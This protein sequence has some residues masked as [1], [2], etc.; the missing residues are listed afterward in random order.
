MPGPRR[1]LI[2]DD[3]PLAR[4]RIRDLLS[5]REDVMVIGE[6]ADGQAA[7][8]DTAQLEPDIL[9]LDVQMPAMDGFEVV[10]AITDIAN[11][12]R[13]PI[14]IF[15]TAY[16]QYAIRAFDAMALDYLRK[17]VSRARLDA[18]LGRA[19]AQLDLLE[20]A[21]RASHS[22]FGGDRDARETTRALRHTAGT[23]AGHA[24][25][26]AVRD[27]DVVRFVQPSEIDWVD[28]A[29]NYV[30]LHAGGK[31]YL[32]RSPIGAFEAR[33]D[34]RHFMRVHRSAIV[35]LDRVH[36]IEPFA[37]GE[38]VLV[39]TDGTRLRSSRAYGARLRQLVRDGVG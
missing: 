8:V 4:G 33:L 11:G 5:E 22:V 3:E 24:S 37:R 21:E 2:V 28:A 6:S 32:L 29:E 1:V 12:S 39:L 7:V 26:F 9:L 38:F 13:A 25:R 31:A 30:R 19:I 17:P 36:R 20:R 10:D 34:P 18:A 15:V 35:N 27:K 14:V 16:D 23:D